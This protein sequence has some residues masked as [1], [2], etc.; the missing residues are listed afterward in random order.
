[1]FALSRRGLIATLV[2]IVIVVLVVQDQLEGV[3]L[4]FFGPPQDGLLVAPPRVEKKRVWFLQRSAKVRGYG[5]SGTQIQALMDIF[6]IVKVGDCSMP[7][8][9]FLLFRPAFL[10][11]DNGR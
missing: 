10:E 9:S 1:M 5:Q 7:S 3:P 4:N 6:A 2:A 11:G 8:N